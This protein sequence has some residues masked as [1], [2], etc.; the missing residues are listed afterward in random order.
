MHVGK[1]RLTTN[2]NMFLNWQPF[3]KLLLNYY[4]LAMYIFFHFHLI[5][6]IITKFRLDYFTHM[7]YDFYMFFKNEKQEGYNASNTTSINHS[8]NA[9]PLISIV[10]LNKDIDTLLY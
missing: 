5:M 7:D 2:S 8:K 10:L 1:C 4:L 3:L 6:K 9:F